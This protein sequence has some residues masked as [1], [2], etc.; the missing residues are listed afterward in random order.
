M[1]VL[2]ARLESLRE[3]LR[4]P[5]TLDRLQDGQRRLERLL[6]RLP[7]VSPAGLSDAQATG[8]LAQAVAQI[9]Q[10]TALGARL[11]P[12]LS[13]AV[14]EDPARLLAG[15]D[16]A[17]V[18][19]RVRADLPPGLYARSLPYRR[20]IELS[21]PSAAFWSPQGRL[22][23]LCQGALPLEVRALQHELVHL[24][25]VQA[26]RELLLIGAMA[27]LPLLWPALV[28]LFF[29]RL[30]PR[31]ACHLLAAQELQAHM[32]ELEH[33]EQPE[34]ADVQAVVAL[35]AYPFVRHLAPG[36]LE[37]IAALLS[38]LQVLGIEGE[39]LAA[40]L[41]RL[42]PGRGLVLLAAAVRHYA[43]ARG[44]DEGDLRC[45]VAL[46][47]LQLRVDR[48]LVRALARAAVLDCAESHTT[49]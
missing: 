31:T 7:E 48:A 43:A 32:E 21:P 37:G 13:L 27:L 19:V 3:A 22:A 4:A 1:S 38:A 35:A 2:I 16:G 45:A 6:A 8:A 46:R 14:L 47:R 24:Q 25:Q 39:G 42:P 18:S 5:A 28:Y 34:R 9:R 33:G 23:A 26:R 15:A 17:G 12:P 40:L 41:R 36:E 29:A 11:L 44:W 49:C 20:R 10:R 30:Y